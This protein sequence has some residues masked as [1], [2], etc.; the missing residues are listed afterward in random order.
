MEQEIEKATMLYSAGCDQFP[1]SNFMKVSNAIFRC[2]RPED[3][4]VLAVAVKRA[5]NPTLSLDLDFILY[6]ITKYRKNLIFQIDGGNE[7]INKKIRR[8]LVVS[9]FPN[10]I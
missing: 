10:Y 1:D 3:H 7:E 4:H 2:L 9:Y 6:R 8:A 5:S